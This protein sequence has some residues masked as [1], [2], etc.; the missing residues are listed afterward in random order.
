MTDFQFT[1]IEKIFSENIFVRK[2]RERNLIN[3]LDLIDQGLNKKL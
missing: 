2:A 3:K 1:P